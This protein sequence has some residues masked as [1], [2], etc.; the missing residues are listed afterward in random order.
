M[1]FIS[2]FSPNSNSG[3]EYVTQLLLTN[4]YK[5][6]TQDIFVLN[7]T[8][9][10]Q[11]YKSRKKY[12]YI[13]F[14]IFPFFSPQFTRR[15]SF[16]ILKKIKND[17]NIVFNF[18]QT[19]IYSIFLKKNKKIFIVHDVLLQADYRSK[20]YILIPITYLWEFIFFRIIKN[21][22]I[23]VLNEKDKNFIIKYYFVNP[24][25]IDVLDIV[26]LINTSKNSLNNNETKKPTYKY[27]I[28][29]A[30]GRS[31]NVSGLE[32][33]INIYN[34]KSNKNIK[35][36]VCGS[37]ISNITPL[38]QKNSDFIAGEFVD[39]I[40]LFFNS[41]EFL[42]VPLNKGAGIKIKVLQALAS[43]I[44]CIGTSIAFEGINKNNLLIEKKSIKEMVEYI[45]ND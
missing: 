17:N 44:Q 1:K 40:N 37:N 12:F 43:N 35:I 3:G 21:V 19:F 24:L 38:L 13:L 7:D 22:Q 20:R 27:G 5:L 25:K 41:I 16:S 39:N 31:E 29:G 32:E 30:W 23:K 18:T 28:I 14:I 33:F 8:I 9:D 2:A 4:K 42:L 36:Y 15:F 6:P 26:K 45:L 10:N 34:N 11:T